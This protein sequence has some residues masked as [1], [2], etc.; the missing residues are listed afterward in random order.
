[1]AAT[2][3]K[4]ARPARPPLRW[5]TRI[6]GSRPRMAALGLGRG[7]AGRLAGEAMAVSVASARE[8]PPGSRGA[9]SP[10]TRRLPERAHTWQAHFSSAAPRAAAFGARTRTMSAGRAAAANCSQQHSF[11]LSAH[12]AARPPPHPRGRRYPPLRRRPPFV[13]PCSALFGPERPTSSVPPAWHPQT[14]RHDLSRRQ[15]DVYLVP[16]LLPCQFQAAQG[17]QRGLTSSRPLRRPAPRS[18]PSPAI[19]Q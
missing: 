1:M 5:S 15:A 18:T 12:C 2:G 3:H 17:R 8:C 14:R 19:R 10:A 7:E 13:R 9:P 11:Q 6:A 4:W 16:S